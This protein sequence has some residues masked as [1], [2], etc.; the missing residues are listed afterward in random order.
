MLTK[1]LVANRGE[2]AARVVRTCAELGI[3]SVAVHSDPD[4]K[5]LHVRLADE[6]VRLPGAVPVETY[7]DA[8]RLVAAAVERGA[9]AVHPGY[10]F[11]SESAR[12]AE[13]VERAG[14]TFVG[15]P[16]AAIAALGDKVS[17]RVLAAAAGVPVVPGV[18]GELDAAR[19]RNLGETHGWPVVVKAAR[20]GGGRG[21]R[22]VDRP[23]DAEVMLASARAEASAAF[24]DDTVY[25]ERYLQRPRHIEI[26][27]FADA[28]G[29]AVW[30]GERDCSVQRRHQKL[31]EEAPAPGISASL[32]QE[33]G[34]AAVRLARHVGYRGA[35]TVEFLVEDGRFHF[36]E[37]NTRI[38]VEHPVTEAVLG[39]DL[40]REQLLVAGGAHL[41]WSAS[42]PAPR[43]HAVECRL[44]AEDPRRDFVPVPGP[45][46]A[47]R[48][49]W[50]PGVRLDS[51]YEAG[52]EIP[53]HY[54][55][56]IA[57]LIVWGPTR[58]IALHRTRD[59]LAGAAIDGPPTTAAA[60]AAVLG[61]P[62]YVAGGV[63]TQWF[64]QVVAP[65]LNAPS[66]PAAAARPGPEPGDEGVW[67]AGRFHR[68]PR[69]PQRRRTAPDARRRTPSSA[70][71][72]DRSRVPSAERELTSP[73]QGTVTSV[74]VIEGDAVTVGQVVATVEAMKMEHQIRAVGDG[75]VASV[76][77]HEGQIVAAGTALVVLAPVAAGSDTSGPAEE[78]GRE[79]S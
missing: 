49:P 73:M 8:E 55:S 35:G 38:Q 18:D 66:Q 76:Y 67:I 31:I 25:A 71:T 52:D 14:L 62:D 5:A 15:P 30:L 11:L 46:R 72:R 50:I 56:L 22:V 20:G 39:L 24:G 9:D 68:V 69:P 23:G 6:A 65:T 44:N 19:L 1:V 64:E 77:A 45:L 41:S 51:G 27:V 16:P 74:T 79:R 26:Q 3:A 59:V 32:R 4:E 42:G 10:G 34:E 12:F 43:G 28:H 54:D 37:M 13:L 40:V 57:K 58:E 48:I 60:A 61:H 47:L 21:M 33:M 36:L 7:L 63:S 78:T 2:I 53:P 75:V 29:N 17:A 70:N